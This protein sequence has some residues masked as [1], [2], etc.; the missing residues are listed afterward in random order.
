MANQKEYTHLL[1]VIDKITTMAFEATTVNELLWEA[2]QRI[3]AEL[4]LEDCVFFLYDESAQK[5]TQAAA[6]GA[7]MTKNQQIFRPIEIKLGKGIVGS[8]AA[9]RKPEIITDTQ[10]DSRYIKDDKARRSEIAVPIIY[11]SRLL[12][13]LDSEHSAVGFFNENH[14]ILFK[15]IAGILATKIDQIEQTNLLVER[16]K[17]YLH[18]LENSLL[19]IMDV[20]CLELY[21]ELFALKKSHSN[22]KTYFEKNPAEVLR[23][24]RLLHFKTANKASV[25]FFG[26]ESADYLIH[27]IR[28]VF[29]EDTVEAFKAFLLSIVSKESMFEYSLSVNSFKNKLLYLHFI[30]RL[31]KRREEFRSVV[32]TYTDITIEQESLKQLTEREIHFRELYTDAPMAYFSVSAQ[33][34]KLTRFNKETL[35]LFGYS[36]NEM[37]NTSIF[38]LVSQSSSAQKNAKNR[39]KRFKNGE[40]FIDEIVAYYRKDGTQFWGKTTITPYKD[41]TGVVTESRSAI[42]DVTDEVLAKEALI[43]QKETYELMLNNIP[44]DLAIMSVDY[45]F[46]YISKRAI[47]DDKLR[48]F[49]IGKDDFDYCAYRGLSVKIAEERQRKFQIVKRTKKEITWDEELVKSNGKVHYIIRSI[50]PVLDSNGK[51]RAL[52]GY[53]IDIT[54]RKKAEIDR[55]NREERLRVLL[56]SIGEAVIALDLESNVVDSNPAAK[57]LLELE[58]NK[59][60]P[61]K[62]ESYLSLSHVVAG[63]RIS[64]P[65]SVLFIRLEEQSSYDDIRLRLNSGKEYSVLLSLSPIYDVSESLSG[66]VLVLTDITSKVQLDTELQKVQRLESIGLLA[67]GIAHDFNNLLTSIIGNLDLALD[68]DRLMDDKLKAHLELTKKETLKATTL[69][70][71]LLTFSK[72]GEPSKETILIDDILSDCVNFTLRGSGIQ[73]HIQLDELAP[74]DADSGQ[75][76]QVIQN[77]TLNAIQ[78][79]NKQGHFEVTATKTTLKNHPSLANGDY[80]KIVFKDSGVG[81][82]ER[83]KLRIF[84]PYY[85]TKATGTGLG[86]A[87]SFSIIHRHNGV[88]EVE[89]EVGQGSA[90]IIY[91]PVSKKPLTKHV[92]SQNLYPI[93]MDVPSIV[94][95]DDEEAILDVVSAILD[96]ME[97]SVIK[98]RTGEDVLEAV[99][100]NPELN[101]FILD[102]TIRGG[103][104]GY[105]TLQKIA[106]L[107]PEIKAIVSS[108]YSSDPIVA[109]YKDYGFAAAISKPFTITEFKQVI[110]STFQ[111]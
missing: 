82:T 78:A 37:I 15:A 62:L 7:K 97:I 89:S 87:T 34:K 81:L 18:L 95:L 108:G 56:E 63:E 75:L 8:V 70:N 67:G 54:E 96:S 49:M 40:L 50:I 111:F 48:E 14:L 38:D 105:E 92:V 91:L 3:I 99:A 110:Y 64:L 86:L 94:L 80:L 83:D 90:F 28:D 47:R 101:C 11:G 69:S 73:G 21:D 79:M 30:C 61:R 85:S 43:S 29:N 1:K 66:A 36:A 106:N 23:L 93:K 103:L 19:A 33:T 44:I 52:I 53:G 10:L 6:Y 74:I 51:L 27:H 26:A 13:V 24:F 72:G 76:T 109:N 65:V 41:A 4:G 22:V 60:Q 104:G 16:E 2:I 9:S 68:Y 84:D 25:D 45:K 58:I 31:P 46:V 12:G 20:D 55:M 59:N 98:C 32:F 102:L 57:D 35:K 107:N 88:I 100:K 77:I 17:Y 71:Q 5:F 42:F 39:Y